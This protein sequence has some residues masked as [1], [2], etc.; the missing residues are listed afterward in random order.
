MTKR[1]SVMGLAFEEDDDVI[2][3]ETTAHC[4]SEIDD[5]DEMAFPQS[6]LRA[7]PPAGEAGSGKYPRSPLGLRDRLDY[8]FRA[9]KAVEEWLDLPT[10]AAPPAVLEPRTGQ[11]P[12]KRSKQSVSPAG[13]GEHDYTS[14]PTTAFQKANSLEGVRL[15]FPKKKRDLPL[16]PTAAAPSGTLLSDKI[17]KLMDTVREQMRHDRVL[18]ENQ[19]KLDKGKAL[20]D[21]MDFATSDPTKPLKKLWVDKYAPRRY[22][23]LVGDEQLNRT[24]L[25]WVKQWDYCVFGK[26]VKRLSERE[27]PRFGKQRMMSSVPLDHKKR[28][29]KK[30][31][32]LSGPPGLG[33]TTLAHVIAKHAGYNVIEVN[34]SDDRTGT[35][36]KTKIMSAIEAKTTLTGKPNLVIIDEIDGASGSGG[37]QSFIQL[38]AK[39]VE[40]KTRKKRHGAG[41]PARQRE[42][43]RP[44]ICI[45]NDAYDA[46]V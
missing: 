28:P 13:T 14:I 40:G 38:L 12:A 23:D 29:E 17:S 18:L 44:I 5:M 22:V 37:D 25:S 10:D 31:L 26:D 19:R 42:L 6:N 43:L 20:H 16:A 33:K 27:P 39:L 41:K 2:V 7:S 11:P 9:L 30:I 34:A 46:V 4:A 36:L 21:A 45:C 3:R 1:T 24:V 8:D 15:Y 32:L 35:I